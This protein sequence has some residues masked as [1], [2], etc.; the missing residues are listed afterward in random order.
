MD[1]TAQS[2]LQPFVPDLQRAMCAIN[3]IGSLAGANGD[4][5]MFLDYAMLA[6]RV[7]QILKAL[8]PE[9]NH[10]EVMAEHGRTF[11]DQHLHSTPIPEAFRKAFE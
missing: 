10:S 7:L 1:D 8:D 4:A 6:G 11:F 5:L 9:T 3:L 2:Q